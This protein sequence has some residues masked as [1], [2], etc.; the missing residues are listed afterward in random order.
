M[1]YLFFSIPKAME[2]IPSGWMS[3]VSSERDVNPVFELRKSA[4]LLNWGL[5]K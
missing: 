2:S 3:H 4:I 5:S 1:R